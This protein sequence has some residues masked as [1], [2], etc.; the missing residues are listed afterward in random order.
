[1]VDAYDAMRSHRPYRKAMEPQQAVEEL[2]RTSGSHFDP[3]V[4]EALI[5]CQAELEAIGRWP[6]P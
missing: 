2:R 6:S 1:M 3:A 4:V 5:R